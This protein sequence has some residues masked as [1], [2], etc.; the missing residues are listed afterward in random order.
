MTHCYAVASN[1]PKVSH[2]DWVRADPSASQLQT[3]IIRGVRA[4]NLKINNLGLTLQLY[5][6]V[7]LKVVQLFIILE[8]C[9]PRIWKFGSIINE[10]GNMLS[11]IFSLQ[12]QL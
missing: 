1:F 6:D 12:P 8:T 10:K 4:V 5:C 3:P 9:L 11:M 2:S 7:C